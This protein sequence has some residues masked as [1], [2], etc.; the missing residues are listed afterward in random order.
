MYDRKQARINRQGKKML[1]VKTQNDP[2]TKTRRLT[3]WYSMREVISVLES[4]WSLQV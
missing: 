2:F 4:A 1:K 3:A